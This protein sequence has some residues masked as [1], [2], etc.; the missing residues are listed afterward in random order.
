MLPEYLFFWDHAPA[1]DGSIGKTC[2]SQW[3]DA[4]FTIDHC[5]Y[6]TAEHYMMACKARLFGDVDNLKRIL[7][8]SHPREAKQLGRA[9]RNFNRSVW[10][11]HAFE[12][13][14]QGNMAKFSQNPR[15][16]AFLFSTGE[17]V[18]VEASPEDR[19]WGIGLSENDADIHHP[20]VWPGENLCGFAI[21][22][23][24]A[25]LFPQKETEVS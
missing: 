20:E 3:Y 11:Q 6:P 7:L 14:V 23:A 18:L 13:V 22:E 4:P 12:M 1:R 17:A 16:K 15:L 8:A 19:L 5:R 25:R 9:V 10:R 2:L 24:R 21:M